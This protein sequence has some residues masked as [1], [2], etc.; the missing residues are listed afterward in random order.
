MTRTRAEI[1]VIPLAIILVGGFL[2][3]EFLN[4]PAPPP[5]EIEAPDF[6]AI[7]DVKVKKETFFK[8]KEMI[9]ASPKLY[10]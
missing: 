2:W 8:Q 3:Y 9:R 6:R 10:K 5:A 1:S 7:K 4:R